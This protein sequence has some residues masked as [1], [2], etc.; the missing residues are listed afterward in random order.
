MPLLHPR[1]WRQHQRT[2]NTQPR[3]KHL[4]QPDN[5]CTTRPK[6]FH[7]LI[8][9]I[10]VLLA[11]NIVFPIVCRVYELQFCG[12]ADVGLVEGDEEE[13]EDLVNVDEQD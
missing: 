6:E 8:Q 4:P 5:C 12:E 11:L 3:R 7:N 2:Q 9:L 10:Q 13:R 1:N